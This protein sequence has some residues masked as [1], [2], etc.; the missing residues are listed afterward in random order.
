MTIIRKMLM[1][2]SPNLLLFCQKVTEPTA[3]HVWK[4]WD[5]LLP[6]DKSEGYVQETL[7]ALQEKA[8]IQRVA[9]QHVAERSLW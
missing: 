9:K 3:L 8:A 5:S 1:E 4:G 6:P 7:T 2:F